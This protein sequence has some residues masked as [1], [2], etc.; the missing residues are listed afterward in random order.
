MITC[1]AAA[2]RRELSP[3]LAVFR[4][5]APAAMPGPSGS[6]D[7]PAHEGALKILVRVTVKRRHRYN[8]EI[9]E[10]RVFRK[11]VFALDVWRTRIRDGAK[12]VSLELVRER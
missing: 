6:V 11:I 4:A 5:F 10:R 7:G 3:A 1:P 12:P 8:E 9:G 2:V